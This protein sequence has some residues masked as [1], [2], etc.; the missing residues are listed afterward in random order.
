MLFE[1]QISRGGVF[2]LVSYS[3][4]FGLLLVVLVVVGQ[5]E[6]K[7]KT[8]SLSSSYD[9]PLVMFSVGLT[10]ALAGLQMIISWYKSLKAD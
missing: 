10:G 3:L 2:K 8:F 4:M 9:N 6:I 1:K 7:A 5:I